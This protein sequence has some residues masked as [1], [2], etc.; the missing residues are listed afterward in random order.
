[1]QVVRGRI[2]KSLLLGALAI[3]ALGLAS[4]PAQAAGDTLLVKGQLT[5]LPRIALAPDSIAVVELRDSTSTD[6]PVVAERRMA[7]QGRQVPIA[8]ELG[9]DRA[10]LAPGVRYAVRGGILSAGRP[11]WASEPLVVDT[12]AEALELGELVMTPVRARGFASTLRCGDRTITVGFQGDLLRLE[13]DGE[14]IDLQ[15]VESASGALF[16]AHTDPPTTFWSKGERA[17]LVLHGVTYP[18][19]V[20]QRAEAPAFR[21]RGNE[22]GWSL[23]IDEA[24]LALTTRHGEERLAATSCTMETS[25]GTRRYRADADGRALAVTV[26]GRPCADTMS[27][28]PHPDTVTVMVDDERLEGCGGDPLALLQGGEWV[29][30][31]IDGQPL[32]ADSRPTLAFADGRVAGSAS[33]NRYTGGFTLTGEGLAIGQVATTMMAC[34]PELMAQEKLFLDVLAAVRSFALDPDGT[35]VLRTNDQRA[36]T[37]RKA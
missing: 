10:V 13:A 27:G 34:P 24:G 5:Y 16:S 8:F 4:L 36:I 12:A 37:A 18:E 35:L 20:T 6:A 29:A 22:P 32:I 9:V 14:A 31:A 26:E 11:S 1:L 23:V 15:Q 21:A 7:L 3:L 28:L 19:C 2:G 17:T 30:Q 25:G 33:C